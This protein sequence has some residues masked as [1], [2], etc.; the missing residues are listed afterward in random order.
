MVLHAAATVAADAPAPDGMTATLS[1]MIKQTIGEAVNSLNA[2][3]S[4]RS[5]SYPL[6]SVGQQ[7]MA[8]V[9]AEGTSPVSEGGLA[10]A[11]PYP[12]ALLFTPGMT[13]ADKHMTAADKQMGTAH[14]SPS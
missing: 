13:A 10:T 4:C 12:M 8:A 5:K 6:T 3:T 9:T 11:C 2:R 14:A 7:P 1:T